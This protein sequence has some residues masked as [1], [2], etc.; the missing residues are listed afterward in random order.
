MYAYKALCP[1]RGDLVFGGRHVSFGTQKT[2]GLVSDYKGFF[3]YRMNNT[4]C[5]AFG[6]DSQNR[7]YGF[8]IVENQAKENFRNNENALWLEGTLTPLPPVRITMPEGPESDWVI[9][10]L[11]G[12]VD[13]TFSPKEHAR[14]AFDFIVSRSEYN[15]PFG[16]YN[17]M[18]LTSGGEKIGVRNLWGFGEKLYLR[19]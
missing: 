12:M 5:T 4:W 10:D 3:P 2:S 19:V 8:S 9:Q 1:V 18:V 14:Y 11:E 6:L 16:V 13:L 17:G 15:A 7:R